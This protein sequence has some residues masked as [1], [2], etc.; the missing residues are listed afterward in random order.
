MSTN[1]TRS[2]YEILI[3]AA[4]PIRSLPNIYI[5]AI[6]NHNFYFGICDLRF[7]HYHLHA[8]HDI[9]IKKNQSTKGP[10]SSVNHISRRIKRGI[11]REPEDQVLEP[12]LEEYSRIGTF[13][14][15]PLYLIKETGTF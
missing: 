10:S 3:L 4:I 1:G 8:G 5:F 14:G 11:K 12:V 2:V 9:K 7:R 13:N 6:V 15:Y